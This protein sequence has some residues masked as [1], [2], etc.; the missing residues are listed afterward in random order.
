MLHYKLT[1]NPNGPAVVFLHGFLG[2]HEDWDVVIE[3]L[4]PAFHCLALDLPGHGESIGL[5]YPDDYGMLRTADAII[6]VTDEVGFDHFSIVG[7]SM[8]G[9]VALYVATVFAMRIDSLIL[10]S[11]SPGLKTEEERAARRIVDEARAQDFE[12][13]DVGAAL[14]RWYA[15]PLFQRL[16]RDNSAFYAMLRRRMANSPREVAQSLR[17]LGTGVQPPL[18]DELSHHTLPTLLITGEHDPKFQ[19]IAE[20]MAQRCPAMKFIVTPN[21]GHNVHFERPQEYADLVKR[22]L[23]SEPLKPRA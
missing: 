23:S 21:V 2:S 1:G 14:N 19:A 17:C 4:A 10:E 15:Q 8:G 7:Y 16:K 6:E 13:A 9:R 22:F 18:W 5:H 3:L 11:A 20:E 12:T